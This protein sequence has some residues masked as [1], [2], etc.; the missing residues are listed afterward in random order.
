MDG[1][2]RMTRCMQNYKSIASIS[3]SII[4]RTSIIRQI[5]KAQ[6]HILMST[7][8]TGQLASSP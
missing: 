4:F 8:A 1:W 3:E 7:N 2:L 5:Y 6:I